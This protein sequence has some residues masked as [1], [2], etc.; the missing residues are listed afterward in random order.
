MDSISTTIDNIDLVY[1]GLLAVNVLSTGTID[2][3]D[4]N[5]PLDQLVQY[6]SKLISVKKELLK[7]VL[8]RTDDKQYA[9]YKD[10]Y[11]LLTRYQTQF[12]KALEMKFGIPNLM[13]EIKKISIELTV[14]NISKAYESKQHA[15]PFKEVLFINI[16]KGGTYK[17]LS[18]QL[19]R[20]IEESDLATEES[21]AYC[22]GITIDLV[23]Q[24]SR[25]YNEL[26]SSDLGYEWFCYQGSN[27]T[28]TRAFCLAMTNRKYFHI[29]EIAA[30]LAGKDLYYDNDEGLRL[31]VPVNNDTGLAYG[32]IESTTISNFFINVGGRNCGH[33]ILPSAE[34]LVARDAPETYQ[35]I[36]AT[37]QYIQWKSA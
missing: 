13:D 24:F 29:T 7:F 12:W 25:V 3:V 8:F 20:M 36:I 18:K 16:T 14:S 31:P 6:Y 17:S 19:F 27:L 10:Y 32:L 30:L 23:N 35:R 26:M 2:V 4:N 28:N 15:E 21:I 34:F 37:K 9:A 22:D 11:F 1:S 5:S 33:V